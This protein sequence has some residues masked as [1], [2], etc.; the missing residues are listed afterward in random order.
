MRLII[1]LFIFIATTIYNKNCLAQAG[2]SEAQRAAQTEIIANDM[3]AQQVGVTKDASVKGTAFIV[4]QWTKGE[5]ITAKGV[6]VTNI[7]LNVNLTTNEL[8]Y[9]DANG[10]TLVATSG[11]VLRV[12][13]TDSTAFPFVP[14]VFKTGYPNIGK[15]DEKYFYQVLVEGSAELVVKKSKYLRATKNNASGVIV[16]EYDDYPPVYY[17][18]FKEIM[19]PI[20][21]TK[22]SVLAFFDDKQELIERYIE[23]QNINFKKETDLAKIFTYYNTLIEK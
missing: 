21:S 1:T 20:K 12:A 5:L 7:N 11:Q 23:S 14:Y 8:Y 4:S 13:F 10:K 9:Q 2:L 22:K 18:Y 15:Q 6:T 3:M 16:N 19:H 17:V